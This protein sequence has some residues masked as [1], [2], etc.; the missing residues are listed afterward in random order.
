M[1]P[2]PAQLLERIAHVRDAVQD[3]DADYADHLLQDLELDIEPLAGRAS[4]DGAGAIRHGLTTHL[5]A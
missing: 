3:G 5:P 4:W 2:T 1:I